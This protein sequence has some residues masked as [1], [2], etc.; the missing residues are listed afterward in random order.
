MPA[1]RF[2]P[3]LARHGDHQGSG[4]DQQRIENE[5][6][7]WLGNRDQAEQHRSDDRREKREPRVPDAVDG[8]EV[9][10]LRQRRRDDQPRERLPV[11]IARRSGE[12]EAAPG[13]VARGPLQRVRAIEEEAA[14][15]CRR[16][17]WRLEPFA[18]HALIVFVDAESAV[19]AR[20][21]RT[22]R[23]RAG[24]RRPARGPQFPRRLDPAVRRA[25]AIGIG[26]LIP[27]LPERRRQLLQKALTIPT[28]DVR[29]RARVDAARTAGL[30]LLHEEGY[31]Y[32]KVSIDERAGEAAKNVVVVI[33]GEP[34]QA[35]TFGPL[36]FHGQIPSAKRDAVI[37]EF[38]ENPKCH[39][40]LTSYGAG[41]QTVAVCHFGEQKDLF[42]R[43]SNEDGIGHDWTLRF[44]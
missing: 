3:L 15:C 4:E 16:R 25:I 30:N 12:Q 27:V 11:L 7:A 5:G 42:L 23:H 21:A 18:S 39:V 20:P 34:G 26:E 41:D 37:A 29:E 19:R 9:R 10:P 1:A 31:P 43:F 2:A 44:C 35:A 17:V 33:R 40:L 36:E 24:D 32:A 14:L 28:G 22:V 13:T 6:V 38:R 8:D